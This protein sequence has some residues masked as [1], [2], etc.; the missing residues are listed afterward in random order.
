M[1]IEYRD[2]LNT[3]GGPRVK[4]V[5]KAE[6]SGGTQKRALVNLYVCAVKV[7]GTAWT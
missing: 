3:K 6:A 1:L 5:A 2:N 7:T 4:W